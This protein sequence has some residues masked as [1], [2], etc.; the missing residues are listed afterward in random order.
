MELSYETAQKADIDLI[1]QLSRNQ[2]EQYEDTQAID[3]EQVLLWVRQK[4]S[5]HINSYTRILYRGQLAGFYRFIPCE[6][7]MELDDFYVLPAFRGMGIGSQVL[8]RCCQVHSPIMLYV[9]TRNCRAIALYRRFGFQIAEK[10]GTTR[11]IMR[12]VAG[13]QEEAL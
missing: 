4:I 5:D 3:L 11:I 12:R 13:L 2:V 10:V 8:R 1:F 9:F 6:E 7:E